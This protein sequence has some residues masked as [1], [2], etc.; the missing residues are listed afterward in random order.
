LP[1]LRRLIF[2]VLVFALVCAA[3]AAAHRDPT[4]DGFRFGLVI[5]NHVV[6]GLLPLSW[7]AKGSITSV[8]GNDNGRHHPGIDI[9]ILRSLDVDAAAPGRV[10]H[11]GYVRG[12]EGY[13]K[14]VIERS[15]KYMLLYAHLSRVKTAPGQL[16][17]RGRRIGIA[18][19]TGWCTG[20]HLHF[21]IRR[22]RRTVDP[23]RLLAS[24][25]R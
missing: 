20:T 25:Q 14:V 3:P 11:T 1:R 13:G 12:Y 24:A 17:A 23:M 21:E 16:I 22:G 18:G 19:C 10:L 9:G 15:G 4:T 2:L 5:Q 7:P 6:V 8:Y